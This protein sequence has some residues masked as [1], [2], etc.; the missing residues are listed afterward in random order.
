MSK[1]QIIIALVVLCLLGTI[2]GSVKDKKATNL[3]RQLTTMRAQGS[4]VVPAVVPA[5]D[6]AAASDISAATE[7]ALAEVEALTTQNQKLLANA[8]TLKGSVDSQKVEIA[9][10]KK[11]LAESDG[12]SQALEVMQA[13]L[14]KRTA[15]V[16]VL[17]QAV[18]AASATIEQK[19]AA[20]AA[21][22][23]TTAGLEQLKSTL[24]NSV[25]EYS[26]NNQALSAEVE[27]YGARILSLGKALEER[28]KILVASGEELGRTKLNMNVLL[29][30]IAAQ[31]NSLEILEE[32]RVALEKELAVKFQTI[33]DLQYQLS[34][35]VIEEIVVVVEEV[36]VAEEAPAE[37]VAEE[38]AV[39]GEEV[40]AH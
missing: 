2:W 3:E 12:G 27:R 16:G 7:K 6:E 14:D 32:T 31:N 28:T 13:Q 30:R 1:N 26:I 40:P 15:E 20:L 17:E 18:V 25:D 10:L 4:A 11:E 38:K 9:G 29:S 8:A 35:Q 24:A 37:A 34:D 39:E 23:V 36:P 22:E 19:S 33:E 5:R 21:A